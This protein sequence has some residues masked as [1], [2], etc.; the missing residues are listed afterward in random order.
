MRTRS[1]ELLED[2]S[3]Y[4]ETFFVPKRARWRESWIDEDGNLRP[5]LKD[6]KQNIGQAL[7]KAIAALEEENIGTLEG[8]LENDIDFNETKG[9]SKVSDEKWKDLLDH[10]NDPRFVL[11]DRRR[12][13]RCITSIRRSR[14]SPAAAATS[15]HAYA[16]TNTPRPSASPAPHRRSCSGPRRI[17]YRSETDEVLPGRQPPLG[18]A[19]AEVDEGDRWLSR[20]LHDQIAAHPK[21]YF[22]RELRSGAQWVTPDRRI[23]GQCLGQEPR[24]ARSIAPEIDIGDIAKLD[25]RSRGS[26]A[27]HCPMQFGRRLPPTD[28]RHI[29]AVVPAALHADGL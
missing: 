29:A 11:H 8:V 7:N 15:L 12:S 5:A 3:S 13:L 6:L 22:A 18:I 4:G 23:T 2:K 17:L 27:S 1:I 26:A 25:R 10:F 21:V 20:L 28:H 16:L 14:R 19:I 9:K 24:R